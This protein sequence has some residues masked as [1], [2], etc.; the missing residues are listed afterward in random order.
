M[1][2][3]PVLGALALIL[4]LA[5]CGPVVSLEAEDSPAQH[6]PHE[7]ANQQFGEELWGSPG[8]HRAAGGI[9]RGNEAGMEFTPSK[10]GWHS[11]GMAC[12]GTSSITVTVTAIDN[13]LGSGSTDCGSAVTTKMELPASQVTISVEG[14][15]A[16]GMWAIAVAPTEAP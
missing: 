7:W 15:E 4:P 2:L 1:T 14:V 12:E 11:I 9:G 3:R 13:V 5:A 16:R 8:A 6:D 10:A